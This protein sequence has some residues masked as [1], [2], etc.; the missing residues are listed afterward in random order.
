VHYLSAA[1]SYNGSGSSVG[2]A[3]ELRAGRSGIESRWRRDF[4]PVQTG[5]G[6]HPASCKMGTGSFP[7]VKCGRGVLLTTH[8]LLVPRS[9]KSIAIPLH[10]PLGYTGPVRDHFTFNLL[11]VTI[12]TSQTSSLQVMFNGEISVYISNFSHQCYKPSSFYPPRSNTPITAGEATV[13]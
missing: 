8:P 11:L 1:P 7:E 2:I 6:V 10:H 13:L 5:P 9:L 12:S 4:S 3:T